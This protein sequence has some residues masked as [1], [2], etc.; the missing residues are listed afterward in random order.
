[1]AYSSPC[2]LIPQSCLA[3]KVIR[4]RTVRR[5]SLHKCILRQIPIIHACLT[6]SSHRPLHSAALSWLG[7]RLLNTDLIAARLDTWPNDCNQLLGP[8]SGPITHKSNGLA[9]NTANNCVT[10]SMYNA[11]R[12][13][14]LVTKGNRSA[15]GHT[16]H[17]ASTLGCIITSDHNKIG[18]ILCRRYYQ[19]VCSSFAKLKLSSTDVSTIRDHGLA[20]CTS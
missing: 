2:Q 7:A 12:L 1:M 8:H 14:F 19:P 13:P 20:L 10:Q 4:Y 18:R 9:T 3:I 15:I 5:D 17:H 16:I 6:H 11:D